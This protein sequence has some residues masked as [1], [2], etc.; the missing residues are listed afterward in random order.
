L[1]QRLL[2]KHSRGTFKHGCATERFCRNIFLRLQHDCWRLALAVTL[3]RRI[4]GTTE[5]LAGFTNR[6]DKYR[7]TDGTFPYGPVALRQ[8]V[9]VY[10]KAV[11]F[12]AEEFQS[13]Y[14]AQQS[15]LPPPVSLQRRRLGGSN[16]K[17]IEGL[18]YKANLWRR[19]DTRVESRLWPSTLW[20]TA[21]PRT[22]N[23]QR[24]RFA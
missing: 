12:L 16:L 3:P 19:P 21:S 9:Q 22:S 20:P 2:L 18:P 24:A 8:R 14:E 23:A 11:E 5:G 6:K 15:K 1:L 13:T 10:S 7:K 4:G 17:S